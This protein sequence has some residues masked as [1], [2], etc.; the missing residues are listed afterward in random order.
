MDVA[1]LRAVRLAAA[2]VVLSAIAAFVFY[3]PIL[4]GRPLDEGDWRERACSAHALWLEE[5]RGCGVAPESARTTATA[6]WYGL[7]K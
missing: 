1:R 4:T 5:T 6:P 7:R 3:F 2:V